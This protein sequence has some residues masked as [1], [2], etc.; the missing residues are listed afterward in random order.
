MPSPSSAVTE[1]DST[2]TLTCI[3]CNEGCQ[4]QRRLHPRSDKCFPGY[5]PES[6]KLDTE[7]LKTCSFSVYIKCMESRGGGES[8]AVCSLLSYLSNGTGSED[9]E[10]ISKWSPN[11]SPRYF[12]SHRQLNGMEVAPRKTPVDHA[13]PR[14]VTRVQGWCRCG[15]RGRGQQVNKMLDGLEYNQY[16]LL[17][18]AHDRCFGPS[19]KTKGAVPPLE[20]VASGEANPVALGVKAIILLM[21]ATGGAVIRDER[22]D[23]E[24]LDG[25]ARDSVT[26]VRR[27]TAARAAMEVDDETAL[28][29]CATE[30]N[31]SSRTRLVHFLDAILGKAKSFGPPVWNPLVSFWSELEL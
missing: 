10:N 3:R 30:E 25:A 2:L 8:R 17:H 29:D 9:M 24:D 21:K 22:D 27:S 11:R 28:R 16:L 14:P 13:H 12:R 23:D 26:A 7:V 6:K 31:D 1:A 18:T 4:G 19:F 5:D 20:L 15:R